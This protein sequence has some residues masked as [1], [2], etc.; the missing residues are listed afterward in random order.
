M[1]MEVSMISTALL[2]IVKVFAAILAAYILLFVACM[3]KM[4]LDWVD[5]I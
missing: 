2:F 3:F 1:L 5:S 4:F